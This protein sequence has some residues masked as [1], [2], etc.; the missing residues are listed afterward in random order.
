MP[1]AANMCGESQNVDDEPCSNE[2]QACNSTNTCEGNMENSKSYG[3][4]SECSSPTA[5]HV[6]RAGDECSPVNLEDTCAP[7][8]ESDGCHN[9]Q[10]V[11]SA[12]W[13][14]NAVDGEPSAC[15]VRDEHPS[16]FPEDGQNYDERR[17]QNG[18]GYGGRYPQNERN[19]DGGCSESGR[20]CD[21]RYPE[22]DP[23]AEY[24]DDCQANGK[25]NKEESD[26]D[27][28]NGLPAT[29]KVPY[30]PNMRPLRLSTDGSLAQGEAV[31][32][33]TATTRSGGF[34]RVS[35]P[36]GLFG[37]RSPPKSASQS[38]F[39]PSDVASERVN[40]SSQTNSVGLRGYRSISDLKEYDEKDSNSSAQFGLRG[41]AHTGAVDAQDSKKQGLFG[42]L[43]QRPRSDS[44]FGLG[45]PSLSLGASLKT[46]SSLQA[47]VN[48][49]L[50]N[51]GEGISANIS[52]ATSALS[53][54]D[55]RHQRVDLDIADA[56][57]VIM[58]AHCID[59]ARFAALFKGID[60]GVDL[61]TGLG[62]GANL[63]QG[64]DIASEEVLS[65]PCGA[66][67]S[68]CSEKS[69]PVSRLLAIPKSFC[70][71]DEL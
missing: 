16:R 70:S 32:D 33:R 24:G 5:T 9:G 59:N 13:A 60:I 57:Q 69:Q 56:V 8:T 15:D 4:G 18:Q 38:E 28:Y 47:G 48:I 7:L 53:Q 37:Q 27:G 21:E 1:K 45:L 50:T 46:G 20:D 67:E 23:A 19:Y 40:G 43:A 36:N 30:K 31:Q 26:F 6:P 58:Q 22:T 17:P 41:K 12:P 63:L 14:G 44:T 2:P 62:I 68:I 42:R 61:F 65:K 64:T 39:K 71:F 52:A 54:L 55:E 35:M 66:P 51:T 49:P 10:P 29:P 11:S 34:N 25:S 3:N